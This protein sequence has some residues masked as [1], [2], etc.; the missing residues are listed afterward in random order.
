IDNLPSEIYYHFTELT[1]KDQEI[2]QYSIFYDSFIP[3]LSLNCLYD[4]IPL[5]KDND[6]SVME[7]VYKNQDTEDNDSDSEVKNRNKDEQTGN[8]IVKKKQ[9][10]VSHVITEFE[11]KEIKKYL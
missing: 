9:C 5:E 8:Y 11:N 3:V 1:N 6:C 4:G 7:S 2:E 10:C